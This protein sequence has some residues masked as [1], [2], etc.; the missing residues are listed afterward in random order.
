MRAINQ[1]ATVVAQTM[2]INGS[3]TKDKTQENNYF[4]IS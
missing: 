3:L 1:F 4:N 2:L